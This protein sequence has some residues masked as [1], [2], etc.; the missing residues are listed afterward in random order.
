MAKDCWK[1]F[2]RFIVNLIFPRFPGCFYVKKISG[3]FFTHIWHGSKWCEV[4]RKYFVWR[5]PGEYSEPCPSSKMERFP[6]I[7]N[8]F[9]YF[10][11]MLHLRCLFDSVLNKTQSR[12]EEKFLI[13]MFLLYHDKGWNI[14]TSRP[15]KCHAI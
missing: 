5:G 8:G 12:K 15:A 9:T 14:Q 1:F 2:Y 4:L 7:V 11:K 6:K 3:R 13:E 10:C